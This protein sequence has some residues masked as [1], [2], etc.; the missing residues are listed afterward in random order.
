MLRDR[1]EPCLDVRLH[2]WLGGGDWVVSVGAAEGFPPVRSGT[3]HGAGVIDAVLEV[4]SRSEAFIEVEAEGEAS[5]ELLGD[6]SVVYRLGWWRQGT[7]VPDLIDL[8]V[9]A[10]DGWRIVS[11]MGQGGETRVPLFGPAGDVQFTVRRRPGATVISRSVDSRVNVAVVLRRD[12][13]QD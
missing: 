7:V 3:F 11:V 13:M 6:G 2:F 1:C 10:P 8:E 12:K 4:P 9:V 5:V